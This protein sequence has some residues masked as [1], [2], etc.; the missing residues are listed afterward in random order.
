MS[1]L[2]A[3]ILIVDDEKAVCDVLRAYLDGEGFQLDCA[4]S[5][6]EARAALKE[7]FD[8]VILDALL[9]GE[10]GLEL[11][12]EAASLGTSVI[13]M[14]GHPEFMQVADDSRFPSLHKPFRLA[15]L[16]S[17]VVA[18]VALRQAAREQS[19]PLEL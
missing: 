8:V 9:H 15:E 3:R 10:H 19:E 13:L 5:G 11:A 12:E 1:S 16:R 4:N 2:P 17:L 14:S 7:R 18:T 6:S